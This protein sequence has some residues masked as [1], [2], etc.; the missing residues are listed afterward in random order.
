MRA[1][2]LI[3][4]AAA[5]LGQPR[6]VAVI[7][8]RGE[9]L[10]HPE[11]TLPAYQAAVDAGA[12]YFEVD[13]RTTRDGK[14]VLLHNATVDARTLSTGPLREM[15]FDQVRALDA[16]IRFSAAFAGTKIPTFEEALA[17]ARRA[18]AGVYVDVKDASPEALLDALNRHAMAERVVVY[19][20]FETLQRLATANPKIRVMPEAVNV[21]VARRNLAAMKPR[22]VAFDR[23][24]FLD[25]V[26]ELVKA[27]GAE[28]YVDRLG[29]QDDA[30]HWEDAVRRGAT[31]IQTDKPSEL[32]QFLRARGWRR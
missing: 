18:G 25:P 17:L 2:V 3:L 23:N 31:G 1:S 32:V 7:A 30:A 11:N 22:V 24:D 26:V 6:T 29:A 21:D 5:A 16:G 10:A 27:A 19:G 20:G 9:H 15:T 14:L 13:V 8:H 4:L 28:V 12:D